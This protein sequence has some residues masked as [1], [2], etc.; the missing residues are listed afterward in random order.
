[1]ESSGEK[2]ASR[3]NRRDGLGP[4]TWPFPHGHHDFIYILYMHIYL[5]MICKRNMTHQRIYVHQMVNVIPKMV[6]EKKETHH[7]SKN[8]ALTFS[9]CLWPHTVSWLLIEDLLLLS[10]DKVPKYLVTIPCWTVS[11]LQAVCAFPST[12]H[13][14]T[15]APEFI[16][17][18]ARPRCFWELT[19]IVALRAL[20]SC[21][22]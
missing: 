12:C 15:E 6:K 17:V 10:L 7:C 5:Y 21:S 14:T 19:G 13:Q 9:L 16:A 20:T 1:M 3:E 2:A 8:E 18:V 4:K 22:H 11:R